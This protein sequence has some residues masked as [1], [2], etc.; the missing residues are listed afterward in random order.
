VT[1]S[2]P[3]D[4]EAKERKKVT[5]FQVYIPRHHHHHLAL[6]P[7]VGFRLLSQVSLSLS[8]QFLYSVDVFS[9]F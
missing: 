4:Y 9:N 2:L 7:F 6:Q 5:L 8:L 1:R 3:F